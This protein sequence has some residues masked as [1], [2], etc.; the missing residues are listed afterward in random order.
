MNI[1]KNHLIILG[2][3]VVVLAF[4]A[5]YTTLSS[6][7]YLY[8]NPSTSTFEQGDDGTI[9]I[10]YQSPRIS[11]ND[12]CASYVSDPTWNR[13]FRFTFTSAEHSFT[14]TFTE[15]PYK[16]VVPPSYPNPWPP[17]YIFTD[18][19]VVPTDII[20]TES[21]SVSLQT[22]WS[23]CSWPCSGV[24]PQ[25]GW[26]GYVG[27]PDYFDR[28]CNVETPHSNDLPSPFT[29]IV[30]EPAPESTPTP[31]PTA[32]PAPSGGGGSGGDSAPPP[33]FEEEDD[34]IRDEAVTTITTPLGDIEISD[35][36]ERNKRVVIG[37][38]IIIILL[39]VYASKNGKLKI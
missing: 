24:F 34:I 10:Q 38:I 2:A 25:L 35:M 21:Y 28:P 14:K 6:T 20:G 33:P 36:I 18:T 13:N 12:A 7:D 26:S 27:Q 32:T 19:I 1:K 16:V 37:M 31:T 4:F 9:T 17:G 29:I 3:V 22:Y 11:S 15:I 23:D 8:S 30:N 39:I 5:S